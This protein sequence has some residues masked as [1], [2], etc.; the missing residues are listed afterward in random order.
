MAIS[1]AAMS[2]FYICV[3]EDLISKVPAVM[4]GLFSSHRAS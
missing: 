1:A 2:S 3:I 4:T